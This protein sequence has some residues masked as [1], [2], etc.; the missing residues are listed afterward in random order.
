MRH[1]IISESGRTYVTLSVDDWNKIVRVVDA[2][3]AVF[4][5]NQMIMAKQLCGYTQCFKDLEKALE[6]LGAVE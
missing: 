3:I 5:D 2:G 6:D 4:K 1:N